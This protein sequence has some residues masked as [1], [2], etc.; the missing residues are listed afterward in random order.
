MITDHSED[1]ERNWDDKRGH[2]CGTKRSKALIIKKTH[3]GI[4]GHCDNSIGHNYGLI[5]KCFGLIC[6]SDDIMGH[7][8]RTLE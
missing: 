3:N 7:S 2:S 4:V 5:G 1:T 8:Y 6:H